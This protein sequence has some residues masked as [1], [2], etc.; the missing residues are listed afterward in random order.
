MIAWITVTGKTML[1]GKKVLIQ[2]ISSVHLVFKSLQTRIYKLE[3]QPCTRGNQTFSR[4]N[5][6]QV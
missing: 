6:F 5:N 3:Y 2:K 1:V 4:M